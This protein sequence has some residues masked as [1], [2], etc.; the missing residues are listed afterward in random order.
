MVLKRINKISLTRTQLEWTWN[1]LNTL[2]PTEHERESPR[3][4]NIYFTEVS[5]DSVE[6]QTLHYYVIMLHIYTLKDETSTFIYIIELLKCTFE[7]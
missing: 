1:H 7:R 5:E 6:F 2:P 4:L 3:V